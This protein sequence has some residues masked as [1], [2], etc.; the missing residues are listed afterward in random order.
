MRAQAARLQNQR[1]RA[2]VTSQPTT[3]TTTEELLIIVAIV[4]SAVAER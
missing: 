1:H 3:T 2:R 4:A